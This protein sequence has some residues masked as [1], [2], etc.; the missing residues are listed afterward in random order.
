MYSFL[1]FYVLGLLRQCPAGAALLRVCQRDVS[2]TRAHAHA[3]FP[4]EKLPFP[5]QNQ[6]TKHP[7][8]TKAQ[9]VLHLFLSSDC[10]VRVSLL[11]LI[12][13]S[14]LHSI[15]LS[16]LHLLFLKEMLQ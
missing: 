12:L 7:A 14:L 6:S 8:T 13:L 11:H 3:S 15:S 2:A 10:L 4:A 16:L 9:A 5:S 1:L